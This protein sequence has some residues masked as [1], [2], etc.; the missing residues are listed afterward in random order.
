MLLDGEAVSHASYV[1]A[2]YALWLP[3]GKALGPEPLRAKPGLD[4]QRKLTRL[5]QIGL[6]TSL[7]GR[8]DVGCG[9]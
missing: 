7:Q 4:F 6:G 9:G 1:V 8:E 5:T 3:I 2:N